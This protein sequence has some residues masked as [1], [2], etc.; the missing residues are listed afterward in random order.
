MDPMTIRSQA[1]LALLISP[2]LFT[3]AGAQN[4]APGDALISP[5]APAANG[6]MRA[7]ENLLAPIPDDFKPGGTITDS[8][9]DLSTFLPQKETTADWTQMITTQVYHG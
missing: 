6:G 3:M 9:M 5:S 2:W 4:L 8:G 1:A 7:G